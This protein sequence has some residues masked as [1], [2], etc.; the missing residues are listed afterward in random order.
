MG[1]VDE[2]APIKLRFERTMRDVESGG[3]GRGGAASSSA[4]GLAMHQLVL[5]LAAE[6]Y[7]EG[8]TPTGR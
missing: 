7:V 3:G 1:E 8:E 6:F 2:R 5:L 4:L